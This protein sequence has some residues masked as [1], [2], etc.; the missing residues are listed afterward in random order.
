MKMTVKF[1]RHVYENVEFDP[2]EYCGQDSH[3]IDWDRSRL[4]REAHRAQ[5]GILYNKTEWWSI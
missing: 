3:K 1:C 2:C 4:E 5:Y